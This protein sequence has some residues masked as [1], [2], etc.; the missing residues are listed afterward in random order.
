MITYNETH[1][2]S[3]VKIH[4]LYNYNSWE[5][6]AKQLSVQNLAQLVACKQLSVQ[7]LAQLVAWR[8]LP[9]SCLPDQL[10]SLPDQLTS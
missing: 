5:L 6:L 4:T 7:N 3:K 9:G 8:Q 1:A 2:S 10:T